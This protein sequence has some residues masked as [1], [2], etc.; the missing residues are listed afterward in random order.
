MTES[1]NARRDK[2]ADKHGYKK[3]QPVI[4]SMYPSESRGVMALHFS[5]SFKA[6]WNARDAEVKALRDALKEVWSNG[7]CAGDL[8]DLVK[9][10]LKQHEE[11]K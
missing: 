6:G 3:A 8:K 10:A 1:S 5:E 4:R 2:E 7:V 9:E 11:V